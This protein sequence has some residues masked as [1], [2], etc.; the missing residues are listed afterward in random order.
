[1]L[2]ESLFF[3]GVDLAAANARHDAMIPLCLGLGF[4]L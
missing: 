4:R 2:P 1:M 3:V